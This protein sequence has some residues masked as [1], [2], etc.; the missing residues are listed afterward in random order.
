MVPFW[1][2]QTSPLPRPEFEKQTVSQPECNPRR[3]RGGY[4]PRISF[5]C[6]TR[7]AFVAA[8]RRQQGCA[9][10]DVNARADE[11]SGLDIRLRAPEAF[12]AGL[13]EFDLKAKAK[14]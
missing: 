11:R 1:A 9:S 7:T 14:T 4:R 10:A 13:V 2:E 5:D 3:P 6:G 8:G 12:A